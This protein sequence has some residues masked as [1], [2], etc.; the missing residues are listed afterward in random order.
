METLFERFKERQTLYFDEMNQLD[1]QMFCAAAYCL[2]NC[3]YM[4]PAF[5][6]I[7]YTAIAKP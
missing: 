7:Q 6:M 4:F 2:F 1:F 3:F 5:E